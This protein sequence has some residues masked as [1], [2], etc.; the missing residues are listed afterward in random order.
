MYVER[1]VEAHVGGTVFIG[2]DSMLSKMRG[3]PRFD[4]ILRRI[5]APQP[6][7]A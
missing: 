5:G 3:I 7:K 1:M 4:D 2:V 6:Q